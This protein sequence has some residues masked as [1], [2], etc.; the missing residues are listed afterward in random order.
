MC[1]GSCEEGGTSCDGGPGLSD[2]GT[3]G[4]KVRGSVAN[5]PYWAVAIIVVVVLA[6]IAAI[7][8]HVRR[9]P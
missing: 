7:I 9:P 3:D 8:I 1:G 6:T 5:V 4:C 2:H